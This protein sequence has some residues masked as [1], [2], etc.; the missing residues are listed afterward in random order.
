MRIDIWPAYVIAWLLW[1]IIIW[2][3]HFD[4]FMIIFC[5]IWHSYPIV[6]ILTS[7]FGIII[8]VYLLTHRYFCTLSLG[9]GYFLCWGYCLY[10]FMLVRTSP[11]LLLCNFFLEYRHYHFIFREIL[12]LSFLFYSWSLWITFL[13]WVIDIIILYLMGILS[14]S[15]FYIYRDCYKIYYGIIATTI[16]ILWAYCHYYFIF[17]YDNYKSCYFIWGL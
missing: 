17:Y 7:W 5:Y 14:L 3:W 2:I 16:Y 12:V 11:L 6:F 10:H 15:F 8:L 4:L 1:Q 9:H 13:Y